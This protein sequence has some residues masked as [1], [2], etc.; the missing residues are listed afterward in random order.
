M[1]GSALGSRLSGGTLYAYSSIC[2]HIERNDREDM[3]E[4]LT[5]PHSRKR[6]AKRV[7]KEEV[8]ARICVS[9][10]QEDLSDE[11]QGIFIALISLQECNRNAA[12]I[13]K[14]PWTKEVRAEHC[15]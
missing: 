6:Q 2:S 7:K 1:E 15:V 8:F 3:D 5:T 13:I 4:E 11:V 9:F 14:G 12:E 10:V